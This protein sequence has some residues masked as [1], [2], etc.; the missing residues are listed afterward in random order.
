MTI[1]VI[2][3]SWNAKA[4]LLKCLES[5]TAQDFSFPVEI[6]VVDNASTDGS[7]DAVHDR[8]PGVKLITERENL[9][10]SKANNIGIRESTGDYLLLINSDVVV[11]PD[12][13]RRLIAYLEQH[14][15]VGMVG[16]KTFGVDGKVQRSC[17]ELPSLWK[18][19][20]R[21][22]ALD[23]LFPGSKLF[24]RQLMR[25][26]GHN[27]TRRVEVV[28]GCFWALRTEAVSRVGLLDERF[29][30]YG[31][32]IDWC[33][34]FAEAGWQIFF[35]S[36]AEALHYGGGSSANA[37]VRF[38][39][40][41]QRANYQYWLKHYSKAATIGFLVINVLHHTLRLFCEIPVALFRLRTRTRSEPRISRNIASLKWSLRALASLVVRPGL[42][43]APA[44]QS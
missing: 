6:I 13:F 44:I 9:G 40:E 26:W 41:M 36:E 25:Y 2:I 34:R 30:M 28:N 29:F 42:P 43:Q 23:S 35:F 11:Y 39:L 10:F 15:E 12:C 21:A 22:L 18:L 19:F 31:E 38:Y 8:F 3:V 1:S 4:L 27:D 20:C 14:R 7:P 37:P 33:K 16:P 17:M 24:G 32:D 5:I